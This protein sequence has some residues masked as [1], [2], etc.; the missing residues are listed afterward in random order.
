MLF[1]SYT[2][3][4]LFLPLT[5]LGYGLLAKRSARHLGIGWLVTASLIYYG[6]WE[7]KYLALLLPSVLANY[8]VGILI[9]ET[10]SSTLRR[11]LLAIGVVGN[12]ALLG[13]F[14]YFNFFVVT[15]NTIARTD[16]RTAS[17]V[18]PLGISF[19]TFQQVAYLVDVHSGKAEE[20][21]LLDYALFVCFFPQLIAGP[22]V[23]H[24]EI[25]PQFSR[26]R[27]YRLNDRDFSVGVT[28]FTI[29]LFKKVVIADAMATFAS[30]VFATAETGDSLT[31]WFAWQG[32]LSY[33]LQLYFDFSGYSDMAIGAARLF[34]IKL[35]VNFNSPYKAR[36]MIDFWRR[37]HMTLSRF[38][39]DYL[40]IPL[41]GNRKGKPRRYLNLVITMGLGGLWH[42]AAWTFVFWG[43][44]HG[45]YLCINH[46]YDALAKRLAVLSGECLPLR[47]FYTGLTFLCVVVAWVF[48]RAKSFDGAIAVLSGMTHFDA[49]TSASFTIQAWRWIAVIA[50]IAF[51]APNSQELLSQYE[52]ALGV[53]PTEH[54][55][56][57]RPNKKWAL[58]TAALA[59]YGILSISKTSEFIYY[60]F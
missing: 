59:A 54:W 40:Y 28:M 36:N 23:H 48:F 42:G 47:W 5:V 41:G 52:P 55:L 14:K 31:F 43:L 58:V 9:E 17:I 22:I 12:L 16:L 45:F 2:F 30:P 1:N 11:V 26:R 6:W 24:S 49:M 10:A 8:G 4:L 13:Y 34:G 29:G 35:P 19:F 51:F 25:L 32:A 60:Q 3:V 56:T 39:R 38:L 50:M 21:S 37:W 15:I 18:L 33:T 7:P 46:A 53:T 44:L 27:D 57:W 20:H